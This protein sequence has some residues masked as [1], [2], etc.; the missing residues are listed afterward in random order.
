MALSGALF[1]AVSNQESPPEMEQAVQAIAVPSDEAV[2]QGPQ[3][4]TLFETRRGPVA[5]T[6]LGA[7]GLA[8]FRSDEAL[9]V[10]P[11]Y[12]WPTDENVPSEYD[13]ADG[14]AIAAAFA[15]HQLLS[16]HAG[17]EPSLAV[18]VHLAESPK[19][20]PQPLGAT[21]VDLWATGGGAWV[22]TRTADAGALHYFEHKD[23]TV[24]PAGEVAVGATPVGF[25]RGPGTLLAPMFMERQLVIIDPESPIEPQVVPL[26]GRPL[27]AFAA[28]GKAFVAAAN[29]PS[30]ERIDGDATTGFTVPAPIT[31]AAGAEDMLFGYAASDSTLYRF[32]ESLAVTRE[33]DAFPNLT[34]LALAPCSQG[35]WLLATSDTEEPALLLIDTETLEEVARAP[36]SGRPDRIRIYD[37]VAV[38]V[39]PV[40]GGVAAFKLPFECER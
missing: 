18:W 40:D 17:T 9:T 6:A 33:S 31:S 21:P 16:V 25:F 26:A 11:A 3:L 24:T 35:N 7:T 22:L 13:N 2:P 8:L 38:V 23:G 37:G 32:D 39:S 34:A 20:E 28:F 10:A 30:I 1:F 12:A 29:D 19:A 36:V 4:I 15:G 14:P 27:L 5:A